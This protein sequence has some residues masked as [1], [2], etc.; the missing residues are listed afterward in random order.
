MEAD[1]DPTLQAFELRHSTQFIREVTGIGQQPLVS[2]LGQQIDHM[3]V[4]KGGSKPCTLAR[5]AWTQK[6]KALLRGLYDTV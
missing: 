5:S 2:L 3:S 4:G 6:K 1:D